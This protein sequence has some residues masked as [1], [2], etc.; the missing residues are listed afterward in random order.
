MTFNKDVQISVE[1]S[2]F[3]LTQNVCRP[4]DLTT[5]NTLQ[6]SEDLVNWRENNIPCGLNNFF[7]M[8]DQYLDTALNDPRFRGSVD[9]MPIIDPNITDS[10]SRDTIYHVSTFGANATCSSITHLCNITADQSNG[11]CESAP[12]EFMWNS[13]LTYLS[14]T[15]ANSVSYPIISDISDRAESRYT[16]KQDYAHLLDYP[17]NT[18]GPGGYTIFM[19][20]WW[21]I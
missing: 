14:S 13:N 8:S 15:N 10:E 16:G 2:N 21:S 19:Q 1:P 17:L 3:S 6:T 7:N 4:Y 9:D 12:P 11:T 18:T 20:L 5:Y